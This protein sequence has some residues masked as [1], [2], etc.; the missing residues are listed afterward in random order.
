MA[1]VRPGVLDL[2][3]PRR[4]SGELR[5]DVQQSSPRRR[6][7]VVDE[8]RDDD[9]EILLA[10][11]AV[12]GVG[13]GVAPEEYEALQPLLK[14]L[15]AELGAS[16]KVTDKGWLP[17]ARQIGLTGRSVAPALFVSIGAQ[18]KFNHMIGTR[19]AGTVLAINTDP[20]APVFDWSDI[21]IVADWREAVSALVAELEKP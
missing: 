7:T 6:V 3:V 5:I 10:A 15:G 12:V 16:R 8:G 20:G 2:R 11:A 14:L 18:G 4:P 17:R 9:V 21:G 19:S 1:T 13:A